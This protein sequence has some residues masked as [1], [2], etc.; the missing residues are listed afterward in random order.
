MGS[1]QSLEWLMTQWLA[2]KAHREANTRG[3]YER[4]TRLWVIPHLGRLTLKQLDTR[5]AKAAIQ[6]WVNEC[7]K[8]LGPKSVRHAHATLSGA[9][10]WGMVGR[11]R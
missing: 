8:T 9:L 3:T 6:A 5:E 11:P 1:R 7:R 4:Y 10:N 2:T